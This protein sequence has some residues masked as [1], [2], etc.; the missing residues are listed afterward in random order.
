[1]VCRCEKVDSLATAFAS[2][3][4][5]RLAHKTGK[6]PNTFFSLSKSHFSP[7]PLP[8][9]LYSAKLSRTLAREIFGLG[10][11]IPRYY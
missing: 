9:R 8:G 2:Q 3:V 1:M 6:P 11:P 7:E 5:A 10:H 4:L